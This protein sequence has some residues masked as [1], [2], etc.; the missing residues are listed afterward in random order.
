MKLSK[1]IG[2]S[3]SAVLVLAQTSCLKDGPNNASASAGSNNVVEFQNTAVPDSYTSP[4]A[5]Y[6]NGV[7]INPATDT[8]G[9]RININYTG[10]VDVAPQ[11]IT[12]S[13]ALSQTALD[14]FNNV[15]GSSFVIPPSDIYSFPASVTIPKG[16]RQISIRP[17]I[18]AAPDYDYTQS[19]CLPMTITSSSYGAI[20]SNYGTAIF[21]FVA[22]N[23]FADNYTATGYV[24]HPSSPRAINAT[25]AVTTVN[26]TANQFPVGDLGGSGYYFQAITPTSGGGALTNY[27]AVGS[28]PSGLNSGFMT[29]DDPGGTVY[30]KASPQA[31]GTTPW[32]SS[33]YNN[34]Y[35]AT[36]KIYWL[37]FG[38]VS[39]GGSS[40]NSYTRQFYMELVA[41]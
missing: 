40:Q 8:G 37:H 9:F 10:P 41:Q 15:V 27:T 38:Y 22:N 3:L 21:T 20:S 4:F 11:D 29:A 6:D 34:S 23:Q 16:T 12:I 18:T 5:E 2:L 19:Y 17:V 33:T 28:T 7:N 26:L 39:S 35:D 30:A 24:F 36:K 25:Y 13:L 32:L 1:N 14:S 31:P